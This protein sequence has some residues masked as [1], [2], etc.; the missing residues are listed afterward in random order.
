MTTDEELREVI[1]RERSIPDRLSAVLRWVTVTAVN[2]EEQTMDA[3]GVTDGLEFYDIQLG[4]DAM[5]VYPTVGATCLV[6]IVEGQPSD[7][8]L[9]SASE[10]ERV[11]VTASAAIVMNGGQNGG[12]INIE[13]LTEKI[14][15]L[16]DTFNRHTHQ[17]STTGSATA[18]TGTAAAVT[19]PADQL[20]REDY[21][22]KLI[23]H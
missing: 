15:T 12:L 23:T 18:Q 16:V 20:K 2:Q 3:T 10:V 17:V 22:D 9:L 4:G 1:L 21:E 5:V 19:S 11:E 13:A 7:A 6:A 14:N 8:F